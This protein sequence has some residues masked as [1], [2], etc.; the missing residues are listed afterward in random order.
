MESAW[1]KF[2]PPVSNLAAMQECIKQVIA[3]L[4]CHL[5]DRIGIT[6]LPYSSQ[7]LQDFRRSHVTA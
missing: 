4:I 1:W 6:L 3:E 2:E 5:E 7:E